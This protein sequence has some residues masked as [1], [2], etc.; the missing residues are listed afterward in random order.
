M[1]FRKSSFRQ[2]YLSRTSFASPLYWNTVMASDIAVALLQ[3]SGDLEYENGTENNGTKDRRAQAHRWPPGAVM[4]AQII[5]SG[6]HLIG[7]KMK[8]YLSKPAL[9]QVFCYEQRNVI[10]TWHNY[11]ISISD[12]ILRK[13]SLN[14][15][16]PKIEL[17]GKAKQCLFHDLSPA[18]SSNIFPSAVTQSS[19][20]YLV[21][22]ICPY[23]STLAAL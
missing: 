12:V 2:S 22:L 3:T 15:D 11:L 6:L 23:I 14:L 5:P 20:K 4:L 16:I 13:L 8:P 1:G 18:D 17:L 10:S 7:E 9:F 21:F 19:C